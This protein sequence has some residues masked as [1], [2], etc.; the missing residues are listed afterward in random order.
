MGPRCLIISTERGVHMRVIMENKLVPLAR[1][2]FI[3]KENLSREQLVIEASGPY[4]L[5]EKEDCF[6]L[7]NA[8]C[9]KAIMVTVKAME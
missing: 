2:L 5:E 3:E 9:C 6:V 8:D 7:R 1:M 4:S